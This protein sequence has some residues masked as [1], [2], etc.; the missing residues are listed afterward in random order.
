VAVLGEMNH[1]ESAGEFHVNS[2]VAHFGLVP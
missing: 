2:W 1:D